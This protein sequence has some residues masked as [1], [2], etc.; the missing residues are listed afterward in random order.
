M[1]TT[2]SARL[3]QPQPRGVARAA[4]ML[5]L[6]SRGFSEKHITHKQVG[7]SEER[8][9]TLLAGFY[10]HLVEKAQSYPQ[11]ICPPQAVKPSCWSDSY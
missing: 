4:V 2:L 9:G 11:K 8:G 5:R 6:Y 1:H 7:G 10:T 3:A